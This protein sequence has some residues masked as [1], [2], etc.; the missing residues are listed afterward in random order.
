MVKSGWLK[1]EKLGLT[2]VQK[3]GKKEKVINP[4]FIS[5]LK[6]EWN[7]KPVGSFKMFYILISGIS[8]KSNLLCQITK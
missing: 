8:E 3:R 4:A 7:T 2:Q 1:K 5:L 6:Q